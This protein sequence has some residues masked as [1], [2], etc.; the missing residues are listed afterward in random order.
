MS[1]KASYEKIIKSSIEI[2]KAKNISRK[3][4][5]SLDWKLVSE[6]E[7]KIISNI[8]MNIW[9][10]GEKISLEF[11]KEEMKIKSTCSFPLQFL[12]WGKNK[13]NV[14]M[15]NKIYELIINELSNKESK[16]Y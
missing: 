11:T 13:S 15:F 5:S 1:F 8:K 9:S 10:W 16:T 4:I 7:N 6:K 12:D 14:M 2:E 3:I